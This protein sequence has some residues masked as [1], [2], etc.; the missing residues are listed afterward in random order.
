MY[1]TYSSPILPNALCQKSSIHAT[2]I[3]EKK[4]KN[5][6]DNIPRSTR[7]FF[8]D[9]SSPPATERKEVE[10]GSPVNF[11]PTISWAGC[12]PINAD[13]VS[14][15]RFASRCR[16]EMIKCPSSSPWPA[17]ARIKLPPPSFHDGTKPGRA[18]TPDTDEPA[19]PFGGKLPKSAWQ[20][21]RSRWPIREPIIRLLS[22]GL[23]APA[24]VAEISNRSLDCRLPL[25]TGAEGGGGGGEGDARAINKRTGEGRD[26]LRFF[27]FFSLSSF[28]WYSLL[29]LLLFF[30]RGGRVSTSEMVDNR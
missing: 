14:A 24:N 29:L 11:S 18:L 7:P 4:E 12:S 15:T 17:L 26:S 5:A 9:L 23:A 21:D 6:T 13:I 3:H 2:A 30:Y 28:V 25:S 8:L 10:K 22:G 20:R 27:F 19:D 1:E 16:S